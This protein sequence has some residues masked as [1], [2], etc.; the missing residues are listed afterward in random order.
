[1]AWA[2]SFPEHMDECPV[3]LDHRVRATVEYAYRKLFKP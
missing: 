1:M 3:V 2:V